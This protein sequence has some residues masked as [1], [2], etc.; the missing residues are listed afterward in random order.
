MRVA[1]T[2]RLLRRSLV[3]CRMLSRPSQSSSPSSGTDVQA[4][5]AGAGR[6]AEQ[7]ELLRAGRQ[8]AHQ[9]GLI[10]Q[11]IRALELD[12]RALGNKLDDLREKMH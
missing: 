10:L 2:G 4:H 3:G 8:L 12:V 1:V 7:E 5:A 6:S 11:Q 9:C